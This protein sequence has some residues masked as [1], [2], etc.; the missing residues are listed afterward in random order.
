MFGRVLVNGSRGWTDEARILHV[1]S[2]RLQPGDLVIA[3][4]ARGADSLAADA[5]RRLGHHVAEIDALWDHFGKTAGHI[6]NG[7]MLDL[8][9]REVVSFWDGMSL[10]THGCNRLARHREIPVHTVKGWKD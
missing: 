3:G 2:E 5:A 1:L 4:G 6:R 8:A 9:P 10:G 7:V